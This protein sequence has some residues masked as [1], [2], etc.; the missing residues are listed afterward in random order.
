MAKGQELPYAEADDVVLGAT[1]KFRWAYAASKM[2]DEFLALSY[3]QQYKLPVTLVRLFNTVGPRQTGQY[4]MVIPRFVQQALRNEDITV[5]G[6]GEQCRCFCDIQDVVPALKGLL[7]EA[8][9][10]G[11]LFNIG[12]REEI[13]IMQLA[14][15]VR[16]LLK[17]TSKI[18][19]IPYSEAYAPGFEDMARRVPDTRRIEGLL[20]WQSKTSL[21]QIIRRVADSLSN[22]AS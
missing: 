4:R 22:D 1:D 19:T 21:D 8:G 17:S 14:T 5:Y 13:S 16:A 12:S 15:R 11:K 18:I 3:H 6:D 20:G 2:V 10:I 7:G 9:A